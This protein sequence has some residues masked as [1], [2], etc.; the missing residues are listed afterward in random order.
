M[1]FVCLRLEP[2]GYP[3]AAVRARTTR[4]GWGTQFGFPERVGQP[5]DDRQTPSG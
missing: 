3:A 4:E 2:I 5:Q 1:G